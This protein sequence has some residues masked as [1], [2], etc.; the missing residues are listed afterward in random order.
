MGDGA[1]PVIMP[2]TPTLL[3]LPVD[4]ERRTAAVLVA[5]DQDPHN[6]DEHRDE[7]HAHDDHPGTGQ[8]DQVQPGYAGFGARFLFVAG[9]ALGRAPLP[10]QPRRRW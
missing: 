1:I 6:H 4:R 10:P 9:L 3:A 8:A 5:A 7:D 2:Q